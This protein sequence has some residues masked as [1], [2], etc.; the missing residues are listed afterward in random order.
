MAAGQQA[1]QLLLDSTLFQ[2]ATRL[3]LNH[4]FAID[5]CVRSNKQRFEMNRATTPLFASK[6]QSSD[7]SR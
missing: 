1:G 6:T 4:D 3:V 7:T 5:I 2:N